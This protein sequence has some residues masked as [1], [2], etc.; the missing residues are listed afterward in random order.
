MMRSGMT[1]ETA[2]ADVDP[3]ALQQPPV[4]RRRLP[5]RAVMF[6][7]VGLIAYL[8]GL[9]AMIPARAVLRESDNLRVGGTIWNGEAVLGSAIR[10]E[11]RFSPLSSL[12]SLGFSADW[13]ATGGGTD[14]VGGATAR[15][16]AVRFDA[17]TGQA[18][19]TLLA[20]LAPQLR[21]SC[22]F[23]AQVAIDHLVLGGGG[24]EAVGTLKTSP[25]SCAARG[26]EAVPVAVPA[27][28]AEI[29]PGQG[30]TS[31][32]LMTVRRL[33]LVEA[34]LSP[35]GALSIWPTANAVGLAPFLAGQRYDARIDW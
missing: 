30:G 25:A 17:I 21:F 16:G 11:W 20:A 29:G 18:D 7:A 28:R 6:L 14:L 27:L 15:G 33:H 5:G 19:G 13:R 22:R 9:I 4:A 3:L 8:L 35:A 23:A 34:R 10:I 31:A 1:A 26:M 2:A 32:A 24:Q 12:A